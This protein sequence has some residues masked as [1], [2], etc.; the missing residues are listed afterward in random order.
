MCKELGDYSADSE[1]IVDV[2]LEVVQT[3]WTSATEIGMAGQHVLDEETTSYEAIDFLLFWSCIF[4]S[5]FV[6]CQQSD[7]NLPQD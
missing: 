1:I 2:N 3:D 6:L 7:F 4:W 5:C